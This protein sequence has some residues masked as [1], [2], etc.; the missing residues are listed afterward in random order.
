MKIILDAQDKIEV[1]F[2]YIS[3]A[4]VAIITILTQ[5]NVLLRYFLGAPVNG[6][7][8]FVVLIFV[9]LALCSLPIVQRRKG[10]LGIE[11]V[12][13]RLSYK[14]K[15]YCSFFVQVISFVFLDIMVWQSWQ[16]MIGRWTYFTMG[17][18]AIPYWPVMIFLPPAFALTSLRVLRQM[19]ED[20]NKFKNKIAMEKKSVLDELSI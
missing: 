3:A 10:H 5:I 16:F 8:E 4:I 15:Y 7:I 6:Y 9:A 18:V 12:V 19:F 1:W 13:E 2:S 17:V 11:F 14:A 20:I